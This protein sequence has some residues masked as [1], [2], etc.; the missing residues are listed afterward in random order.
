MYSSIKTNLMLLAT[1]GVILTIPAFVSAHTRWFAEGEILPHISSEPTGLYLF[2]I[3][4]VVLLIIGAGVMLERSN[5]LK[6][7][8]FRP[9]AYDA[10]NRAAATFTM[11][12]GAFFMIAGTH[13][14]LFSP[15]LTVESGVPMLLIMAQFA[16]GLMFLLGIFAR[17]GAVLLGVLWVAGL[18]YAGLEPMIE[19]VW[20]LSILFFIMAIGND[21][22]SILSVRSI[23]P[24]VQRL[25]SYALPTLRVGTGITLL[26]LG[27]S[28][29][30][31]RPE[32]G[33]NFL[34]QHDWNFMSCLGFS[35]YL[36]VLSAGSVE[37]LLGILLILGIMTRLTAIVIAI[38]FTIP[39]FI[40]GPIE[41]AGHL[42][43]FAAVL[44]IIIFGPGKHFRLLYKN[45]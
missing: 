30:I 44:M 43:H 28:E 40:L 22:F 5:I 7:S 37:A 36:F 25:N 35:D 26:T 4:V 21:Y 3:A 29:K 14:Y 45:R 42:P 23:K 27:F 2:S 20:V 11:V 18:H 34:S 16:V 8:F 13:E 6:L 9:S 38:I 10:F 19:D 24:I 1:V 12:T 33:L 31:L 32:L 41:L 39:L 17:V 15:N